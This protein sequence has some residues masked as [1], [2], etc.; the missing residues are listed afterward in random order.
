MSNRPTEDFWNISHHTP[1]S[2]ANKIRD[3]DNAKPELKPSFA[4]NRAP[5]LA[6]KG[7]SGIKPAHQLTTPHPT[8]PA[9]FQPLSL[10]QTHPKPELL[11]AGRFMDN[12]DVSFAVEVNSFKSYTGIEGD[13]ITA[14]EI[15]DKGQIIAQYKDMEWSVMPDDPKQQELVQTLQDQF[16]D[17][18]RNFV[19]IVP[20]SREQDIE[21]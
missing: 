10:M 1:E 12:K 8:K 11:T 4:E 21:R 19:P 3:K 13:K 14:L 18:G 2:P 15:Q 17:R 9:V 5:N 6:P 20:I 16:G 7:M